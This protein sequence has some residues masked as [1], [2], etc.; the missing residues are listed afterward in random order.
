MKKK[1]INEIG[2]K[3]GKLIV[4]DRAKEKPWDKKGNANWLCQ[5]NCGETKEITGYNLRNGHSKS[6]GCSVHNTKSNHKR[7][8]GYEEISRTFFSAI[9]D[10]ARHR[11]LT[12]DIS[13]EDIWNLFLKQNRKCALSGLEL[14]LPQKCKDNTHTASLDRIDSTKGYIRGN[15]QWIHKDLNV[16]KMDLP[17]EKFFDYCK[18]VYEH[19]IKQIK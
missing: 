6:C 5:C 17:E 18:L 7:W 15:I 3:Y 2:N 10:G 12:F 1:L 4:I 11:N 8:N 19:K 9:K 14:I 16:M 13:I